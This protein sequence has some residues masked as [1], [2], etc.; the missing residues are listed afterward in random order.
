[1]PDVATAK[2]VLAVVVP[3]P[4]KELTPDKC[5]LM[6]RHD[7]ASYKVPSRVV[8]RERELPRNPAGKLLKGELK[9]Q[10]AA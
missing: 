8:I 9:T 3:Q 1:M 6:L 5:R 4:G 10:Y 7:L 2:A